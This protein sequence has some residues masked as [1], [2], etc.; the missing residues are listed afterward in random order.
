MICTY[1]RSEKFDGS[2][3]WVL[4]LVSTRVRVITLGWLMVLLMTVI[5]A[6][7]LAEKDSYG[8][9]NAFVFNGILIIIAIV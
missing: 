6:L 8:Y 9:Y 1:M 3:R 5:V 4:G 2:N 7:L